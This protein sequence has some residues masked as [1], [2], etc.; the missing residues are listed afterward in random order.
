MS[1]R[2]EMQMEAFV[3]H[4]AAHQEDLRRYIFSL[5]MNRADADDAF[6]ETCLALWRKFDM[7]DPDRP[8]INWACRFARIQSLK[9]IEKRGRRPTLV[10]ETILDLLAE[11]YDNQRDE[12]EER[13]LTLRNCMSKLSE[14]HRELLRCR[15]ASTET[16]QQTAVRTGK[17]AKA[18]YKTLERI[19]TSL[20]RCV[21][22][23]LAEV[24]G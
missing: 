8:F 20:Y 13:R 16:I 12:L 1:D 18:L 7:Y 6:Q 17:S 22:R 19:R 2:T 24:P 5:V 23:K 9:L 14:D 21:S 11:D 15:Y 4:F 3:R 10:D